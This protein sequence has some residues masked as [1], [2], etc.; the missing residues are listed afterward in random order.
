MSAATRGQ[1]YGALDGERA[2]QVAKWGADREGV[3]NFIVYMEEYLDRAKRALTT[4]VGDEPA[5]HELRKVT[6]LGVACLEQHGAP[7]RQGYEAST[8]SQWCQRN[9][10]KE[11]SVYGLGNTIHQT[12][13]VDVRTDGDRVTAVWFRCLQ[14]AFKQHRVELAGSESLR[15]PLAGAEILGVVVR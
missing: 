11:P 15:I 2:Y 14:L 9:Q 4:E 1:V 5:L 3:G 8:W 6:A 7:E 12:T 10:Q 13:H